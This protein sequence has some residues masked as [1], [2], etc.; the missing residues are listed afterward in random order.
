MP[1]GIIGLL[2][3][4]KL[5]SLASRLASH[6]VAVAGQRQTKGLQWTATRCSI[7]AM[8]TQQEYEQLKRACREDYEKN[9]E[10]IERVWAMASKASL[11]PTNTSSVAAQTPDVASNLA[12]QNGNGQP[13]TQAERIRRVLPLLDGQITQPIVMAKLE[14]VD[15]ELAKVVAPPVISKVLKREAEKKDG[16]LELV[17]RAKGTHPTVYRKRVMK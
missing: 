8:W 6:L 1:Y 5:D 9:L 2:W 3:G 11:A 15:P 12:S 17:K 7:R 13:L 16:S 4:A 14:E 10:A